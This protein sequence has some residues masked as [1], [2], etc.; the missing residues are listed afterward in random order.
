MIPS[1]APQKYV[2]AISIL[3]VVPNLIVFLV[4]VIAI[5][6]LKK[7]TVNSKF[8]IN[9]KLTIFH[10]ITFIFFVI[11]N[12]IIVILYFKKQIESS[13]FF[14]AYILTV[15]LNWIGALT[16]TKTLH[17]IVVMQLDFQPAL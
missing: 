10:S 14:M 5:H 17:S 8:Q 12:L 7:T 15:I 4:F 1:P 2:E 3:D 6:K 9:N 16:F 11:S 13:T